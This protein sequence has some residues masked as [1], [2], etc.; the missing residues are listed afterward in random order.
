VRAREGALPAISPV[1]FL[2]N[3]ALP[4]LARF[5]APPLSCSCIEINGSDKTKSLLRRPELEESSHYRGLSRASSF[6]IEMRLGS[7]AIAISSGAVPA[8]ELLLR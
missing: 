4:L 8:V 3:S 6:P 5:C 7:S 1:L 2:I